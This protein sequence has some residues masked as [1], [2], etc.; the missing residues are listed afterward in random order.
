MAGRDRLPRLS[1]RHRLLCPRTAS[2]RRG[3]CGRVG[4]H[5]RIAA[6]I[7]VVNGVH[8]PAA[9]LGACRIV[10]VWRATN[11]LPRPLGV[12]AVVWAKYFVL[13]PWAHQ[14]VGPSALAFAWA[15]MVSPRASIAPAWCSLQGCGER[16]RLY[17]ASFVADYDHRYRAVLL[18]ASSWRSKFPPVFTLKPACRLPMWGHHEG[19]RPFQTMTGHLVR[20]REGRSISPGTNRRRSCRVPVAY[21][22]VA[23][24][25][26]Q[27]PL[28]IPMRQRRRDSLPALA[29]RKMDARRSL[30][31]SGN[32]EPE[33]AGLFANYESGGCF[34]GSDGR[35]TST[36]AIAA[37]KHKAAPPAA[38]DTQHTPA[39]TSPNAKPNICK[40]RI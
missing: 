33:F 20:D 30:S 36:S 5:A 34:K 7:L 35:Q 19:G 40:A 38:H 4:D 16:R 1:F 2:R 15:R 10:V 31:C 22:A 28:T 25:A 17:A 12:L 14:H 24:K 39:I 13:R 32:P 18:R 27:P 21:A 26:V 9:I 8:Y 37:N 23:H 11:R 29:G 6:S 3:L